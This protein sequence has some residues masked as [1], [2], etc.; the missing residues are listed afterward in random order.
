MK[1][2]LC[3]FLG[4]VRVPLLSDEVHLPPAHPDDWNGHIMGSGQT[5]IFMTDRLC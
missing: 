3:K 5:N 1:T 4:W 2:L